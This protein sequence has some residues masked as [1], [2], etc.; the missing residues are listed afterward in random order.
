MVFLFFMETG[1]NSLAY[2]GPMAGIKP[3][4][5]YNVS[6][7]QNTVP[8]HGISVHPGNRV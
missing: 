6:L 8:G 4:L 1:Y 5:K 3:E 7:R 2:S